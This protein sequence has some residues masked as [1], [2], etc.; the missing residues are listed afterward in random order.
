MATVQYIINADNFYSDNQLTVKA[1]ACRSI[2][3]VFGN[4]RFTER[5]ERSIETDIRLHGVV[6]SIPDVYQYGR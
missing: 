5:D 1:R 3:K 2:K 6:V 4:D